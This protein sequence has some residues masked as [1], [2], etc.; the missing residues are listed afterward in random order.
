MAAFERDGDILRWIKQQATTLSSSGV[1]R[2]KLY[3]DA[4]AGRFA[5]P[6]VN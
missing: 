3:L 2:N 4:S 1:T 5:E 6:V